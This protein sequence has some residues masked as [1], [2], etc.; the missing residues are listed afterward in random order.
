M[1]TL[2]NST[3]EDPVLSAIIKALIR[4][5]DPASV[6]DPEVTTYMKERSGTFTVVRDVLLRGDRVVIPSALR[7]NVLSKLHEV[8]QGIV[9][10]KA[11][12]RSYIWWPGIDNGIIA[13][14]LT[15]PQCAEGMA[16]LPKAPVMPWPV[17]QRAWSREHV[18]FAGPNNG[19]SYL[20]MV[21]AYSKWIEARETKGSFD[22][23]VAIACCRDWFA[24]HG[25]PDELV[26]DQ[27]PAFRAE[28]FKQ[29]LKSNAI[30]NIFSAPYHPATN[31]QA[32]RT[33]KTLKQNLSKFPPS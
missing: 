18:D 33:V 17:P 28:E 23:S 29:F 11:I 21:D 15:C 10:T 20:I 5:S 12:A 7:P 1:P 9:K 26:S 19:H 3:R 30:R 6:S 2:V 25:I 22:V 14:I 24:T 31:G 27:G 13:M 4:G 8:H 32:E 16:N